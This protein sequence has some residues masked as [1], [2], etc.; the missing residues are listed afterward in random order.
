MKGLQ[1]HLSSWRPNTSYRLF[2]LVINNRLLEWET[3]GSL[4][5][6]NQKDLLKDLQILKEH[7]IK[8]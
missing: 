7:E 8:N 3:R 2:A 4:I 1:S 6:S 5:S